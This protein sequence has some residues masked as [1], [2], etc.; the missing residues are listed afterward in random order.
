MK[1]KHFGMSK[2]TWWDEKR[3]LQDDIGHKGMK[4]EH[5]GMWNEQ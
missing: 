4:S 2:K 3:L 5:C 1:R